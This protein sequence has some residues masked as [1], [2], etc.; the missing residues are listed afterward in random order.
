[1]TTTVTNAKKVKSENHLVVSNSLPPHR[2]YIPCNAPGQNT[3]VGSN[4][5]LQVN[6]AL[7]V[8]SLPA[9]HPGKTHA[10]IDRYPFY[11]NL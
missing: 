2:L 10:P 4:T 1:M 7:Q 3:G 8:N 11:V 5:L 6:S 9:E